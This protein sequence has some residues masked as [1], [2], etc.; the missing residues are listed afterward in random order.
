VITNQAIANLA[1]AWLRSRGL[2]LQRLER[3]SDE[4]ERL[5]SSEQEAEAMDELADILA[6][7]GLGRPA[8]KTRE[9]APMA[10]AAALEACRQP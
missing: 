10:L 6:L 4:L 9:M 1:L 2:Q 7:A 3:L 5:L 8:G